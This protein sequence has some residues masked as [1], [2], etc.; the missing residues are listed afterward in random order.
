MNRVKRIVGCIDLDTGEI[1]EGN[2]AIWNPPVRIG[3]PFCM[4]FQNQLSE[5]ILDKTFRLETLRVLNYLMTIIDFENKIPLIQKEIA[6]NMGMS[7][8]NLS[9]CMIDLVKRGIIN[10]DRVYGRTKIYS[11]S[12]HYVWRG[13]VKNLI[14][15]RKES[16]DAHQN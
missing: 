13:K 8:T 15:T 5:L 16:L 11:M 2:I 12:N 3:D 7:P 4:L 9:R 6:D 14:K 10:V 1:I